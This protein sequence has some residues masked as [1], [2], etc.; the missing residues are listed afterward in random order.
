MTDRFDRELDQALAADFGYLA[1]A[2]VFSSTPE[3][4]VLGAAAACVPPPTKKTTRNVPGGNRRR[5]RTSTATQDPENIGEF[6]GESKRGFHGTVNP[7][8]RNR[9]V[10]RYLANFGSLALGRS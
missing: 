5:T 2:V 3:L 7:L 9:F 6:P 1:W 10:A 8:R 4:A